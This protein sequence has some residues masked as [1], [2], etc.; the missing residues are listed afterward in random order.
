[1][2]NINKTD[3][4]IKIDEIIRLAKEVNDDNKGFIGNNDSSFGE[5]RK[6]LFNYF[7]GFEL[8][9]VRNP[10]TRQLANDFNTKEND[11]LNINTSKDFYI[12][13]D[14]KTL[15][16][17]LNAL[18]DLQDPEN[19]YKTYSNWKK[20][21]DE[22][23][24]YYMPKVID[25]LK[26]DRLDIYQYFKNKNFTDEEIFDIYLNASENCQ[27]NFKYRFNGF[28]MVEDHYTVYEQLESIIESYEYFK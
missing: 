17:L 14:D 13:F 16:K 22:L 27:Y 23:R 19:K 18:K 10:K 3:K 6:A 9:I 24:N 11:G 12:Q 21:N 20:R 28:E 4:E 15:D 8:E 25:K 5:R 26:N 2:K 1:M 7:K